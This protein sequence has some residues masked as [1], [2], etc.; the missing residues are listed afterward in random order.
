MVYGRLPAGTTQPV[1][2]RS[3]SHLP[4]IPYAQG[5]IRLLAA[6]LDSE[7]HVVDDVP[8]R[9]VGGEDGHGGAD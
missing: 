9:P 2:S 5:D 8:Q 6:P 1:A 7:G 4:G 3:M